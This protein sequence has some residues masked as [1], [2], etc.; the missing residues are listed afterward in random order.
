[1]CKIMFS[2]VFVFRLIW[3][4][5]QLRCHFVFFLFFLDGCKLIEFL[6]F[7]QQ[8]MR[9]MIKQN[10]VMFFF[11]FSFSCCSCVLNTC[12]VSSLFFVVL[13]FG[14][15]SIVAYLFQFALTFTARFVYKKRIVLWISVCVCECVLLLSLKL[16]LNYE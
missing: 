16:S 15:F 12:L 9:E 5:I 6:C 1:M 3:F 2:F 8:F 7:L 4:E 11:C 10:I 14:D 13:F